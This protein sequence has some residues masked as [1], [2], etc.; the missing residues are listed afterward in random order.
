MRKVLGALLCVVAGCSAG[1]G[2]TGFPDEPKEFL[3]APKPAPS[4]T[5]EPPTPSPNPTPGEYPS[6]PY[7]RSLESVVPNLAFTGYSVSE[8]TRAAYGT[9]SFDQIRQSGAKYLLLYSGAF[10]CGACIAK[11]HQLSRRVD[12][13]E[14][15]GVAALGVGVSF[16]AP[17]DREDLDTHL[18]R[19]PYAFSYALDTTTVRGGVSSAFDDPYSAWGVTYTIRLSDMKVLA[20][21]YGDVDGAVDRAIALAGNEQ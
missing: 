16:G 8:Q 19:Y 21:V 17:Q 18:A 9:I 11:A 10:T 6:G 14:A 7:G 13:L 20:W 1:E 12:E 3:G 5:P 15:H 2:S 4:P